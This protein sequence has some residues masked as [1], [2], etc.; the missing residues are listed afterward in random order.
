M[1]DLQLIP[2]KFLHFPLEGRC[3]SVSVT[4]AKGGVQSTLLENITLVEPVSLWNENKTKRKLFEKA[5]WFFWTE[6]LRTAVAVSGYK[7]DRHAWIKEMTISPCNY[8]FQPIK[9]WKEQGCLIPNFSLSSCSWLRLTNIWIKY[10]VPKHWRL[11]PPKLL[12]EVKLQWWLH[13]SCILGSPW[14]LPFFSLN[15]GYD[16]CNLI[17]FFVLR[18]CCLCILSV[19]SLVAPPATSI[20]IG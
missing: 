10:F 5:W 12:S 9:Y 17:F 4:C 8:F 15:L 13:R 3:L 16:Y 2:I 19:L 11:L 7:A 6:F 18:K 14:Q 1:S 20:L